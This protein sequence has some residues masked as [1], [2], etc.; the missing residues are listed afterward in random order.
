MSGADWSLGG[1]GP[2]GLVAPFEA[3]GPD[4]AKANGWSDAGA[5]AAG[6]PVA[7]GSW[8]LAGASYSAGGWVWWRDSGAA[9]AWVAAGAITPQAELTIITKS[10]A[11]Y[12][13]DRLMN[14]ILLLQEKRFRVAFGAFLGSSP[15]LAGNRHSEAAAGAVSF[16]CRINLLRFFL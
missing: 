2:L 10:R 16:V 5:G 14:M 1:W 12:N 4:G 13:A 7:A 6:A 9:G 15:A 8:R 3:W 11:K